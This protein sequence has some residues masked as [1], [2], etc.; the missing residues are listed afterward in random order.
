MAPGIGPGRELFSITRV[1]TL[2]NSGHSAASLVP[3]RALKSE[4]AVFPSAALGLI[5]NP[6]GRVTVVAFSSLGEG[7]VGL[8]C[9]G[10]LRL[11]SIPEGVSVASVVGWAY[12]LGL[13]LS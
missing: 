5:E 12:R 9:C 13:K 8:T 10:A 7:I 1:P 2:E 6:G 3:K 4:H 11:T